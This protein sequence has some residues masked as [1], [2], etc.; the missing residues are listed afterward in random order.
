MRKIL[1]GTGYTFDGWYTSDTTQNDTT[2]Y[3]W[4]TPVTGNVDLYAKW[5]KNTYTITFNTSGGDAITPLTVAHGD[6]PKLPTPT[7]STANGFTFY[8]WYTDR[9]GTNE[10]DTNAPVTSSMTLW[11]K[12]K[13]DVTFDLNGGTGTAP[14]TQ[15]IVYGLKATKPA[16]DPMRD[17][18]TFQGWYKEAEGTNQYDWNAEVQRPV[19]LYAKWSINTYTVTYN[20]NGGADTVDGVPAPQ[21]NVTW[22]TSI[23]TAPT[24]PTRDGYTFAGWYTD[25][26]TS[27]GKEFTFGTTKVTDNITLYAKWTAN[28]VVLTFDGNADDVDVAENVPTNITGKFGDTVQQPADPTR[29]G[30]EFTGWYTVKEADQQT[31]ATKFDWTQPLKS[32]QTLYAGWKIKSYKL[33]FDA[34]GGTGTFPEQTVEYRDAA[35]DPGT[36]TR[37]GYTFLGWFYNDTQWDFADQNSLPGMPAEDVTL[38]AQ[39]KANEYTAT[40][41]YNYAG[42]PMAGTATI[43]HDGTVT[44]P[45]PDPTRAGYQFAGWFTDKDGTIPYEWT[46]KVSGDVTLYAQWTADKNQVTFDTDG[47]SAVPGTSVDTGALV[48]RP[49]VTPTKTGYD[50]VGW[51]KADGTPWNFDTDTAPAGPLTLKAQWQLHEYTVS[52][53]VNG[54]GSQAP[55]AQKV[56]YQQ[57]AARPADPTREGYDFAGWVDQNGNPYDFNAP[58][59]GDLALTAQWTIQQRTVT[60]EVNGGSAVEAQ[61]VA[62]GG[63]LVKPADPTRDGFTFAGWYTDAALTQAYDFNATVTGDLTLY[64]KWTENAASQDKP[65]GESGTPAS[66]T[67]TAATTAATQSLPKTDDANN[68]AVPAAIAAIGSAFLGLA[69]ALRRRRQE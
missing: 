42:A 28:D 23:D 4:T 40:F 61:T 2:K 59:T 67:K 33:T 58:V 63:T 66:S 30:H 11:A 53:D 21:Q 6:T 34:A 45:A 60:F 25:A 38:T 1:D 17:G 3:N 49:T 47:G 24:P 8:K 39:W 52:F 15:Q 12:W 44:A 27:A 37:T 64:A 62:W 20:G 41:D 69:A 57:A 55:V 36:P 50:F 43:Q 65:K 9:A 51:V 10:Y 26:A 7:Y 35:T 68:A 19:T 56:P 5:N 22:N 46:T 48:P 13:L 54:A 31:D 14:Q 18:H 32:S 29:V 16:D